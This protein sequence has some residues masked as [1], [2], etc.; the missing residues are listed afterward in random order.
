MNPHSTGGISGLTYF[1]IQKWDDRVKE[2]IYEELREKFV[3]KEIYILKKNPWV[4]FLG[5][6]NKEPSSGFSF[7]RSDNQNDFCRETLRFPNFYDFQKFW[8]FRPKFKKIKKFTS[9][10]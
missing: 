7:K 9:H 4:V 3:R 5:S 1:M 2:R 10:E 8:R 6:T